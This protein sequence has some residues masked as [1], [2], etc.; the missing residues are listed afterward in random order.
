MDSSSEDAHSAQAASGPRL[1]SQ[2]GPDELAAH[3]QARVWGRVAIAATAAA[4]VLLM[5]GVA[6]SV[7][8]IRGTQL[9]IRDCTIKGGTCYER[10]QKSTGTAVANIGQLSVYAAACSIGVD[11]SLSRDRRVAI[12]SRCVTAAARAHNR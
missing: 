2:P 6:I 3:D 10:G 4:I 11:P 1:P 7:A 5:V 8:L 9:D 12:I